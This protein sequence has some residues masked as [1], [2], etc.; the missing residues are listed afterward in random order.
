M[1]SSR[2]PSLLLSLLLLSLLL[3]LLLRVDLLK[4]QLGG[5]FE[6]FA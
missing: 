4:L 3:L 1:S 6:R 2:S 5:G